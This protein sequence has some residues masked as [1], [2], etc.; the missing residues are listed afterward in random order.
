MGLFSK[1]FGR[2]KK[3]EEFLSIVYL[4]RRHRRVDEPKMRAALAGLIQSVFKM[5]APPETHVK[6]VSESGAGLVIESQPF[7]VIGVGEPYTT[8]DPAEITPDLRKQNLLREH[9]AWLACD[10]ML[11]VNDDE[12]RETAYR[13]MGLIM[14]TVAMLV[15]SDIIA[16]L[17][18]QT[19]RLV[20]YSD[21]VPD[22]LTGDFPESVFEESMAPIL[23]S[24]GLEEEL[25]KATDEAQSRLPEFVSAFERRKKGTICGVKAKFQEGDAIEWMWIT[26]EHITDDGFEGRL[27]NDPGEL[28]KVKAGDRI[29]VKA[30]EVV[31]WAITDD[32][33]M[34]GG[35]SVEVFQRHVESSSSGSK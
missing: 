24:E 33:G 1:L 9:K 18:K 6:Q 22:R 3:D 14:A 12:D 4:L 13:V 10:W 16:V 35:F 8:D 21:N 26:V 23:S 2:K 34:R 11:P 19:G 30:D 32:N 29:M 17:D 31:D 20:P 7:V 25:Q 15:K 27:D 5:D 28:K